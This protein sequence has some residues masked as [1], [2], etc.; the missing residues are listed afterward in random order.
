MSNLEQ[1]LIA[2]GIV[3]FSMVFFEK[4]KNKYAAQKKENPKPKQTEAEKRPGEKKFF[5]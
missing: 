3:I 2:A 5:S 1:M 4:R